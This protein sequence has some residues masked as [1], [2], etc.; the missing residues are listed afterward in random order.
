[1][2]IVAD[3]CSKKNDVAPPPTPN[4]PATTPTITPPADFGFKVVG[5]FPSY[6]DP[7]AIPDVKFRMAN[8][9]TYAFFS[10]NASGGLVLNSP[11]TFTAVVAKT[12][13]NNAKIFMGVNG[14]ASYFKTMA[15]TASGRNSFIKLIMGYLRSY[16]LDGVDMDWEYPTTSD[17]TDVTFTALMKE[18]SDS[19]HVGGKYYLTAAI[20]PGKYSGGIRDAIKTEVFGYAD[21]FNVMVYDDFSTSVPYKQHSDYA[22]AQ[23]CLNYWLNT[24]G[25][26]K[27]KC[28]LGMPAYGRP[29]G[30]TQTNT[31]LTYASILAQGG[32][33]ASDSAIVSASG[34]PSP[35]TIYYNG[36]PTIKK[37]AML[38]K[39]QANGIMMWEFGQDTHDA[40]SLLKAACDTLGRTY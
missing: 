24:R 18:L 12:R 23:T 16:A 13:A 33:A 3:S 11:S 14:D 17:G 39:Q 20:T 10:I 36:Q 9:I 30:I 31:T 22:L 40:T 25:M 15:S 19:C 35:Y 37:K 1:M 7:S 8:V 4:P 2:A 28:V 38:A 21:W 29:S 32:S 27:A 26:P 6:R 34:W 5:Y